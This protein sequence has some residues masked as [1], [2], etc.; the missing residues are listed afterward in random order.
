VWFEQTLSVQPSFR[1]IVSSHYKATLS[2]VDFITNVCFYISLFFTAIH[3]AL[4]FFS[5]FF[6]YIKL[7][8]WD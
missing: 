4:L 8:I 6:W 7:I 3:N 2:S 5:F 1:E